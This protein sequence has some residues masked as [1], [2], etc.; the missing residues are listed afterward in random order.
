MVSAYLIS[1]SHIPSWLRKPKPPRAAEP[2][3]IEPY[4]ETGM[5]TIKASK[6]N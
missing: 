4:A 5:K 2:V 6:T 3:E 1:V